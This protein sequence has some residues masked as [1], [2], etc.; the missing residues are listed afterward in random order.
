MVQIDQLNSDK[1]TEIINQSLPKNIEMAY[2]ESYLLDSSK[3]EKYQINGFV[4]IE[5]LLTGEALKISNKI[6]SAAVYLRKKQDI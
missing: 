6:L 2:K 1:A 5:K 3:I 4:K